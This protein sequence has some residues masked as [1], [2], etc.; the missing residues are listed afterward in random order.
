MSESSPEPL[1]VTQSTVE[2]VEGLHRQGVL[3]DGTRLSF[4]VHGAVKDHYKLLDQPDLPL[5]VDYVVA[6]AGG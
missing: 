5:P 4:G 3:F 1:Y 6:A 2:K